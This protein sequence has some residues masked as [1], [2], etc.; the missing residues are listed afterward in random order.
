[1]AV[2]PYLVATTCALCG[3]P[4]RVEVWLVRP[5]P[6]PF[7]SAKCAEAYVVEKKRAKDR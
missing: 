3:G 7:C 5:L 6:R 2:L 4:L 1:M